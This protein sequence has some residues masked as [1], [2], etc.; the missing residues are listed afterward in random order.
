MK[1]ELNTYEA[2]AVVLGFKNATLALSSFLIS[3]NL[4]EALLARK[5]NLRSLSSLAICSHVN[6][7]PRRRSG[8]GPVGQKGRGRQGFEL[9]SSYQ[10][11]RVI[12]CVIRAWGKYIQDAGD[13]ALEWI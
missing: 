5:T 7:D 9:G 12:G 4:C 3:S 2:Q 8:Q 6:H 10:S 13:I 11:Y 1:R